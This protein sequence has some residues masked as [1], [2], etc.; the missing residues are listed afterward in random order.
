LLRPAPWL[1]L[2]G[3]YLEALATGGVAPL[4]AVNA[5]EVLPPV[6]SKQVEGGA[7]VDFGQIGGS[8]ALFQIKEPRAGTDPATRI[9]GEVGEARDRGIEGTVFGEPTPGVRLLAGVTV[10]DSVF[11]RSA[12]PA[13]V[14]KDLPGTPRFRLLAYGEYDVP[15]VKD[16]T[17]TARIGYFGETFAD[18]PNAATVP[19]WTRFDLGVRQNFTVNRTRLGARFS[20]DNVTNERYYTVSSGGALAFGIPRTYL[21]S[22]TTSF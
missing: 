20:V 19:S 18:L 4:T 16:F 15:R 8:L 1:S 14:G 10:L 3:N 9:F 17:L 13:A 6:V 7:K 5:N 21:L 11:T 22:V 12:T 2:Y